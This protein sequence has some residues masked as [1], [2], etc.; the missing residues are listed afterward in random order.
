[1]R[2]KKDSVS[3]VKVNKILSFSVVCGYKGCKKE[4][5]RIDINKE[6]REVSVYSERWDGVRVGKAE[7]T[8]RYMEILIEY[9]LKQDIG[10][11]YKFLADVKGVCCGGNSIY[12]PL[13]EVLRNFCQEC[14][15]AYCDK[16]H[17]SRIIRE[18]EESHTYRGCPKGHQKRVYG[19]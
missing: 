7:L 19:Y 2:E 15:C 18:N 14:N 1:M 13:E 3:E 8:K 12:Y 16:H 5:M 10:R 11:A 9:L 4:A 17:D 6:N